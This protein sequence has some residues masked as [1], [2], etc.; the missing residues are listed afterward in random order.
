MGTEQWRG[1]SGLDEK[2]TRLF[3]GTERWKGTSFLTRVGRGDTKSKSNEI[4]GQTC[5]GPSVWALNG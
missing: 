1:T 4:N 5:R 2:R 3:M